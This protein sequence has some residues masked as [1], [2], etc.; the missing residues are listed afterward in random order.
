MEYRA[1]LLGFQGQATTNAQ[2]IP[3]SQNGSEANYMVHYSAVKETSC[4]QQY[5]RQCFVCL[6]GLVGVMCLGW[7]SCWCVLVWLLHN[8]RSVVLIQGDAV[9]VVVV[10]IDCCSYILWFL[11]FT[12][13]VFKVLFPN[14]YLQ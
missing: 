7:S 11:A 13:G 8:I 14:H 12:V 3:L 9:V 10:I 4:L 6:V 1:G 5:K 2:P